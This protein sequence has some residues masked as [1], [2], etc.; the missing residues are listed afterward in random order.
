MKTEYYSPKNKSGRFSNT[1]KQKSTQNE[2]VVS[3]T[4]VLTLNF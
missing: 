2:S 4:W 1:P 3:L